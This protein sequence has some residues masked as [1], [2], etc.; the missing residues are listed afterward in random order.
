M[1]SFLDYYSGYHQ[2]GLVEE[3]QEK[4]TFIMPFEVFCYTSM[5]FGLKNTGVTYQRA[6]QTCLADHLGKHVEAFVD[7]VV[8]KT[9]DPKKFID[10]LQQVFNTLRRYHWKHNPNKCVFRVPA[11]KLLSFTINYRGIEANPEKIEA[12]MWMEPP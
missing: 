7:D 12:I 9:N 8:I 1:L 3:D 6:I 4:P 10:D 2:I 11:G 5:P